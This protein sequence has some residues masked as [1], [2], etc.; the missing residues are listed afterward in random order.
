[1][2]FSKKSI[3][4]AA[5]DRPSRKS[6]G[7]GAGRFLVAGLGNGKGDRRP[8]EGSISRSGKRRRLV[9]GRCCLTRNHLIAPG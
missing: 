1:V 2:K 7:G 4:P 6:S 5:T 9:G 3:A 8:G